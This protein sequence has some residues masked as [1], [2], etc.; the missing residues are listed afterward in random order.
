M[1]IT[2]HIDQREHCIK[3]ILNESETINHEMLEYGDIIFRHDEK[4]IIVI[5]RKTLS[6]LAASI[7]DG[8]YHSQ[9]KKLLETIEPSK[10]C[11]IIEGSFS[12]VPQNTSIQGI[13]HEAIVSCLLNTQFRDGIHV[14]QSKNVEETCDIIQHILKRSEKYIDISKTILSKPLSISKE[15][16]YTKK[17]CY[18]SQL[19]QIPG[20]SNKIANCI[21]DKYTSLRDLLDAIEKYDIDA[22]CDIRISGRKLSSKVVQNIIHFVK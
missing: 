4:D 20:I 3:N 21:S 2:C 10:I 19:A 1:N 9:K 13:T 11:Y 6:D 15:K 14:I 7:K 5:E 18:I 17:E 8:R 22:F 16:I 12:F